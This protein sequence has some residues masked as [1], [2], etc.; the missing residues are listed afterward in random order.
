[1]G[2]KATH[3]DVID[4]EEDDDVDL[5]EYVY[6]VMTGHKKLKTGN[7]DQDYVKGKVREKTYEQLREEEKQ[8]RL[9]ELPPTP[10][11]PGIR[12]QSST[13]EWVRKM[14]DTREAEEL[15][16]KTKK[17]LLTLPLYKPLF[18][19]A[20]MFM[21]RGDI[22]VSVEH[23]V[24]CDHHNT[25]LRHDSQEYP[26]RADGALKVCAQMLYDANIAARVGVFRFHANVTKHSQVTDESNRIGACEI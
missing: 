1:M 13:L 22:L 12:T 26:V 24:N 14:R 25:T 11:W 19:Q 3:R 8:R 23:C 7:D 21:E 5:L 10:I 18:Q 2:P 17:T 9:A 16:I 15:K 4:K 6:D 20:Y